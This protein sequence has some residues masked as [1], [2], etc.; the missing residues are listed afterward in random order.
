MEERI[1]RPDQIETRSM[2]IIAQEL[3]ERGIVL[4]E[5]NEAV[6]RRVIH[7]TADFDYA[8]TLYFSEHAVSLAVR[9]LLSPV[10]VVTDTNMAKA[11]ISRAALSKTGGETVCL[12][13]EERVAAAA[14]EAGITRASAAMK[15]AAMRYPDAVYA[16][17]N[18]PTALFTLAELIGSV[19]AFRPSLVVAVP[20]GFVNVTEAKEE[21]LC[22]CEQY[23][24]PV[25]VSRGRKGGS[26]VAA[27]IINALLYTAADMLDPAR[28]PL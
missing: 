13:A 21:I 17:G 15:M 28:R 25:I 6:I 26:T 14:K 16:V 23:K 7:T 20:V 18:A 10:P 2:E 27:A 11:G 3:R 8:G 19:E 4:P 22:C 24:I 5:E 9:A 1:I 12:M